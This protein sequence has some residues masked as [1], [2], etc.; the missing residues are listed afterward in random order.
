[1]VI[2]RRFS[3]FFIQFENIKN[4]FYS[5]GIQIKSCE[6]ILILL[7]LEVN[8]MKNIFKIT[9][10]AL[11]LTTPMTFAAGAPASGAQAGKRIDNAKSRRAALR[12]ARFT[13]K[14]LSTLPPDI[15][16]IAAGYLNE[17]DHTTLG[18]TAKSIRSKLDTEKLAV[19]GARGKRYVERCAETKMANEQQA[20]EARKEKFITATCTT[21]QAL[22]VGW[23]MHI[24]LDTIQKAYPEHTVYYLFRKIIAPGV[25]VLAPCIAACMIENARGRQEDPG[26]I[27]VIL[28][29]TFEY[30]TR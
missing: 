15:L 13:P 17:K 12:Q 7:F 1:M 8:V 4:M 19:D 3:C 22:A 28:R 14:Q 30:L 6:N 18:A 29:Q 21:F 23:V 20:H 25:L 27:E 16:N 2:F 10:L 9:L 11:A 5:Q 24:A 26:I